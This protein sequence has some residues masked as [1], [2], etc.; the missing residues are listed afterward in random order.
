[1]TQFISQNPFTESVVMHYP[2]LTDA[3]LQ[4]QLHRTTA[5]QLNWRKLSIAQRADCFTKLAELITENRP[6]LARLASL[7]MGKTFHEALAEI[8]KCTTACKYYADH[9]AEI[10]RPIL[11]GYL[12]PG[13]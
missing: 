3:E 13:I 5:A 11:Y 4:D 7:E 10:L 2:I 12:L 9:T 1:M 6:Q 8:N